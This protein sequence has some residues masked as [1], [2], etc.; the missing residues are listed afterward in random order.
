M[1]MYTDDTTFSGNSLIS[2]KIVMHLNLTVC[3]K[4][5]VQGYSLKQ[6][7]TKEGETVQEYLVGS[8]FKNNKHMTK[9]WSAFYYHHE[10]LIL[11][12]VSVNTLLARVVSSH[13]LPFLA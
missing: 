8:E 12:Y 5:S 11:H 7:L 4:H 13:C 3:T 10:Q 9:C 6:L 1:N 2:I